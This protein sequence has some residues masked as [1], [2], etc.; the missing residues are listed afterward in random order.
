M[1]QTPEDAEDGPPELLFIHGGHTSKV[2]DFS[3]NGI[4]PW[5]IASVSEDN[6][7]QVWTMAEEIYA[8]DEEESEDGDDDKDRRSGDRRCSPG[9]PDGDGWPDGR[10]G[11]A[12][13][14]ATPP[15]F[16]VRVKE[17]ESI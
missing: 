5:T 15:V 3:W 16:A 17:A 10:R 13:R 7:L 8:D 4:N 12:R 1:E 14:P 6:V 2:N 9:D 11:R